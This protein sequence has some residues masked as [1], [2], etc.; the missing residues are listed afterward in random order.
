MTA[1]MAEP[2]GRIPKDLTLAEF[3]QFRDYIHEHSGIY[4]E[5]SKRDSLRISLVAR[6]TRVGAE[7][8]DHYFEMLSH[9]HAEFRE[10]LSLITINETSFYRF[11]GQF[12]ALAGTVLPELVEGRTGGNQVMRLWSAGCSTGEEPYTMAMSWVDSGLEQ[13]GWRAEI[14]GTDVSTRALAVAKAG[15]YPSRA[16][17]NVSEDVVRRHFVEVD[18]SY[19]VAQHVRRLCDFTFHNLIKEPYPLALMGGCDVIFCRNVTI[20]FRLESTKRVVANLFGSLNEGG[21]LF[22]GHSETLG[23]VSDDFELVEIDGVFVY[24]KPRRT[25]PTHVLHA[26][27]NSPRESALPTP[28]ARR[29]SQEAAV[30]TTRERAE[31]RASRRA[32]RE[33]AVEHPHSGEAPQPAPEAPPAEPGSAPVAAEDP[34]TTARRQMAEGRSALALATV[35][36]L[37]VTDRFNIE[38]HLVAA[39]LHAD[40]GHYDQAIAACTRALAINPLL[41]GAR[42]ILGLIH[43]RQG[44]VVRAVSELKKTVY[45]DPDFALAHLTLGNIYKAGGR[46]REACRAYENSLRALDHDPEG[47]WTQFVGGWKADVILRTAERSLIECRKATGTAS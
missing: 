44:D 3:R 5:E 28:N 22:I 34:L 20:Y 21:Y 37:L 27:A 26:S 16:L 43:Q 33:A 1:T 2:G 12:E 6:A 18:G 39:H 7:D 32:A 23:A 4:L 42:Y 25:R 47:D 36:G 45:I 41:P 24:R 38:A 35:E 29:A 40:A 31:A 15:L 11:P 14:M 13:R 8:W 10:L 9:D 17:L 30:E 19:R 46:F